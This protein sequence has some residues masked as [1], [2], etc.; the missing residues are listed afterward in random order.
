MPDANTINDHLKNETKEKKKEGK[1]R[2]EIK[3]KQTIEKNLIQL[4]RELLFLLVAFTL[5]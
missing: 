3:L 4:K 5:H 2:K 1:S